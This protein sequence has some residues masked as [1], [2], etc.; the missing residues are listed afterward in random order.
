MPLKGQKLSEKTKRKISKANKI[1]VKRYFKNGGVHP[2]KGKKQSKE[3][4]IKISLAVKNRYLSG[5]KFGFQKG[6]KLGYV[7]IKNRFWDKVIKRGENECWDW[8]AYRDSFGYG[9]IG[10]NYRQDR[11]HRISWVLH[12]GKIPKGLCVLHHCDNP[13]CTNPKH[14]FLGTHQ[15]N[16]K[17]KIAKNRQR[18]HR[19]LTWEAVNWIRTLYKNRSILQKELAKEFCV[20]RAT[21]NAIVNNKSWVKTEEELTH[22][23]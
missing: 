20:N 22:E 23:K 7:P 13:P 2:M 3:S 15:D 6:N 18:V 21:I 11:A 19:K 10:K 4:K 9:C 8:S 1:S 5:E 12:Y 14:L 17:D 16:V